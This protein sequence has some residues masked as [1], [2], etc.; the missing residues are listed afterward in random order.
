MLRADGTYLGI[1]AVL[2]KPK[3]ELAFGVH[4]EG[5]QC[6]SVNGPGVFCC[7]THEVPSERL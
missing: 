2:R 3:R 1:I 7:R 4:E 5:T 6:I